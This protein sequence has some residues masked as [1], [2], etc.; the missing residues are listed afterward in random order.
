MADEEKQ[1][2]LPSRDRKPVNGDEA[3]SG[4]GWSPAE[5]YG[6]AS[7]EEVTSSRGRLAQFFYDNREK[8]PGY[9]VLQILRKGRLYSMYVLLALL[10]VY[11]FNQL[12]RYTLPV[13]TTSVGPDLHYGDKTCQVNP[14]VTGNMLNESG[15]PANFTQHCA[16]IK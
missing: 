15:Y 10:V 1:N 14:H 11:L 12:D 2:L 6:A 9:G 8:I 7:E 5:G 13:V 4:S 16:S 3:S